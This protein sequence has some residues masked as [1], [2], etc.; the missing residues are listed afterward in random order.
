VSDE[1]RYSENNVDEDLK[2]YEKNDNN[3]FFIIFE[4][5]FADNNN[6]NENDNL[7]IVFFLKIFLNNITMRELRKKY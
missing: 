7:I 5:D 6:D 3:G 2:E 1:N 4:S